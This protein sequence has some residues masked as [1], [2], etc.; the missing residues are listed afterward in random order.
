MTKSPR[1]S[2]ASAFVAELMNA[3]WNR[4][5]AEDLEVVHQAIAHTQDRRA[6]Q[7]WAD[8]AA[9]ALRRE[10]VLAGAIHRFGSVDLFRLLLAA[11]R[12]EPAFEPAL[13]EAPS[14]ALD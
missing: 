2:I 12:P 10:P 9:R 13:D 7:S 11:Q 5:D 8:R 6:L 1:Q 14:W 3:G 4:R